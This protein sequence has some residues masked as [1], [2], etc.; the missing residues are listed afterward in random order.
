MSPRQ[1][2][3]DTCNEATPNGEKK[4]APRRQRMMSMPVKQ[5]SRSGFFDD[6]EGTSTQKSSLGSHRQRM[7][8]MPSTKGNGFFDDEGLED[9]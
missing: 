6:D 1:V 8:T 9:K 5:G 4:R 3:S 2:D 7:Q